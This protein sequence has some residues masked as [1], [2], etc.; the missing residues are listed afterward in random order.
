MKNDLVKIRVLSTNEI[1]LVP[2]D[3]Y[4][5]GQELVVEQNGIVEPAVVLCDKNCKLDKLAEEN[6]EIKVLREFSEEDKALQKSLKEEILP[7]LAESQKKVFRHGL[8]MEILGGDFSFDKKKLTFYFKAENRVDFRSLV[9][10]M[11]GDFGKLIRLQ[12]IGPREESTIIGGIGRCGRTL[13]CAE[14]LKNFDAINLK[15][16]EFNEAGVKPTKNIG[17]CGRPMCCLVFEAENQAKI[18][19]VKTK[20]KE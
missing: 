17:C 10:D 6:Q 4:K 8:A 16:S 14:F 11:A 1:L 7:Y 5:A 15:M 2:N 3:S 13:C 19:I 12:Q 20:K 9:A 18:K